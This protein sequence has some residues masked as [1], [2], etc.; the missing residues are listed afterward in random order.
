MADKSIS[1]IAW[2][3]PSLNDPNFVSRPNGIQGKVVFFQSKKK[4]PV[5]VTIE[6][7]GLEPNRTRAIHIHELGDVHEGCKS[8]GGHWNP[9]NETHG[10]YIDVD[11]N[12]TGYECHAGDMINNIF[13]DDKG[14]FF[15]QYYDDRIQLH[16]DVTKS[17]IGKSVVIHD[18]IDDLGLGGL[19]AKGEVINPKVH[20]DSLKTGNAGGR[21]A[22]AIIGMAKN[23]SV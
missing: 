8:L 23:S 3:D 18:G 4:E 1:A 22:C 9:T 2:F 13:P 6:L 17:I 20:E 19:N 14:K 21:M 15:Y 11:G 16:G 12:Y 10:E 5:L 7:S